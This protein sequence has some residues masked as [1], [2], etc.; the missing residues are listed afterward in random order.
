M[1]YVDLKT[2]VN[3]YSYVDLQVYGKLFVDTTAA[4]TNEKVWKINISSR[5]FL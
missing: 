5:K 3:L 2:I 1:A 4:Y